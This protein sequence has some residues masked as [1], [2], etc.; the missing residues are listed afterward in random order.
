MMMMMMV[1]ISEDRQG[2]R[3]DMKIVME[4]LRKS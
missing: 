3:M 4:P 2:K 1:N